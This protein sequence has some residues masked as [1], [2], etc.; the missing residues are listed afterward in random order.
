PPAGPNFADWAAKLRNLSEAAM[1]VLMVLAMLVATACGRPS[2]SQDSRAL[3]VAS[4]RFPAEFKSILQRH[5]RW[6]THGYKFV[7]SDG[8][9]SLNVFGSKAVNKVW[10]FDGKT[11]AEVS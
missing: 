4:E 5:D 1:K 6:L 8:E 7:N 10:A 11:L 3:E 9:R 2:S